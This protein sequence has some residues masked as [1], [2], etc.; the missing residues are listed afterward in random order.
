MVSLPGKAR[1]E[2][3]RGGRTKIVF[4]LVMLNF[5]WHQDIRKTFGTRVQKRE[6]GV[7]D[8]LLEALEQENIEETDDIEREEDKAKVRAPAHVC[9]R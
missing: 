5:Q 1:R 8:I 6:M 3:L 9:V 2:K 7:G 4:F